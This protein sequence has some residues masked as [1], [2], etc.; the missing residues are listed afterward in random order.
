MKKESAIFVFRRDLRIKDN[1]GLI[2]ALK[3]NENVIPVFILNP[4]QLSGK[5]FGKKSAKFMKE[6]LIDLN[7]ELGKYHSNL[8]I[9][10][11]KPS[12][13]I[14][15]YAKEKQILRVYANRD[16]TPFSIERDRLIH[17]S[18]KSAEIEFKLYEDYL[19]N[20]PELIVSPTG[21]NYKMFSPFFNRCKINPVKSPQNTPVDKFLKSDNCNLEKLDLID[22]DE[23]ELQIQGGRT[24]AIKIVN[25]L[26][27]FKEYKNERDFPSINGTT[28]FSAH[29]KFGT[30]SVRELFYKITESLGESHPLIRQLYWRDF[31]TYIAFNKPK[32]FG[33]CFVE[34]YEKIKWNEDKEFLEAWKKGLTG[35]PIVDAGMRQLVKTGLMH[36]RVRMIA[37]S[38]L[39]KDLHIDWRKGEEFF[40]QHLI[41]YDPCV[42]N[43]NW[44]W[45]ASTGCDSQ[46]YY[47][48]FNPW[49]QQEKF[50]SDCIYIKNWVSELKEL[51]ARQIHRL[52]E[53]FPN[54]LN[55]PKPIV[56]H[57][58]E[59]ELSKATYRNILN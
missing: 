37:A 58:E 3:E 32:V 30:I 51:T 33:T 1:T 46:P 38:F 14:L 57:K 26:K 15:K 12:E 52:F 4:E 55:Y 59:S 31:F 54:G 40:A 22:C 39:V 9:L 23:S 27:N 43:G 8:R 21:N 49:L 53:D 41:D 5:Y 50:D 25:N 28:N 6:S 29:L 7:K 48:I 13:E 11:G 45:C 47:R 20:S 56:N 2:Y 17:N 36:N 19:L 42:N 35:F 34:K 44:Q 10:Y 18:L 24:H 16:Y